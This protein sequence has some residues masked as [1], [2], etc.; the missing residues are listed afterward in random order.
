MKKLLG[1]FVILV[2]CQIFVSAQKNIFGQPKLYETWLRLNC[3]PYQLK[4]VLYEV[5]DSSVL[6][7]YS[8][9][10]KDYMAGEIMKSEFHY[11]NLEV[12]KTRRL[13]RIETFALI[14]SVIGFSAVMIGLPEKETGI[15]MAYT[16][17]FLGVPVSAITGGI[18]ALAGLSKTKIPI[19][20]NMS[21]FNQYKGRMKRY[22]IM[23]EPFEEL[24]LIKPTYEKRGYLGL[25]L[26]PSFPLG[27]FADNSPAN[28]D[29]GYAKTGGASSFTFGYRFKNKFGISAF[30]VNN[31]YKFD[32][33]GSN[34]THT[35]FGLFTGPMYSV[36]VN[37][38][39]VFDIKPML[40]YSELTLAIDEN[41]DMN[42]K[43]ICYGLFGS[44]SYH[45]S[46]RLSAIFDGGY[47]YSNQ[48][49]LNND[50]K[51]IEILNFGIGIGYRLR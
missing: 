21:D 14:G 18:G 5:K 27:N 23:D 17:F 42:A 51:K 4:G 12:L 3:S 40:G 37:N 8:K 41:S 47:L 43:G 44:V 34:L 20:G 35:Y 49:L 10:K 28:L 46:T 26:G 24:D 2:G 33:V 50:S 48:K 9:R 19:N 31:S 6:I 13:N 36:P 11:K 1:I 32:K 29:A 15:P 45:I 30:S 7:S 39:F 38:K 16:A 25:V 22:S